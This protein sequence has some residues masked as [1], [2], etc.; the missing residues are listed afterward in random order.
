MEGVR[1]PIVP[2]IHRILLNLLTLQMKIGGRRDLS[3]NNSCTKRQLVQRAI[4]VC[5]TPGATN[6]V[7]TKVNKP[8]W[9]TPER[10]I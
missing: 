7:S 8:E 6:K 9:P 5:P 2:S 10:T 1:L 3:S 4:K